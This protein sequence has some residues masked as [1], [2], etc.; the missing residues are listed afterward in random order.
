MTNGIHPQEMSYTFFKE[1]D[2]PKKKKKDSF[3]MVIGPK[4]QTDMR[5]NFSTAS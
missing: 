2:I 1:K 4:Q 3:S 5:S